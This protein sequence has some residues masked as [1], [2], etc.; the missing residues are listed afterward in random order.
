[1]RTKHI[2][3]WLV[4][5]ALLAG[6]G[7]CN[8]VG[9]ETT[10]LRAQVKELKTSLQKTEN[11]RDVLS[12]DVS[13]LD[14][15]LKEAEMKLADAVNNRNAF[16][17]Q[18]NALTGRVDSLNAARDELQ[19]RL[20]DLTSTRDR[21]QAQV[22]ELSASRDSLS[23][24]VETLTQARGTLEAKVASL[25]SARAAALKDADDA[26]TKIAQLNTR[27]TAQTQQMN[28]LQAQVVSIRSVLEQLQQKLQ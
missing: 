5:L 14:A 24:T 11:E 1:M 23:Q 21:L 9:G 17:A 20:A 19:S 10:E 27:L 6:L 3:L 28:E 22:A 26:H 13:R 8:G 16:Q 4:A 2:F 7:G 12:Q 15:S 25:E 18:V